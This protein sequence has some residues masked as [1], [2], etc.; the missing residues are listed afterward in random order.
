MV[1]YKLHLIRH[2]LTAGNTESRYI[3]GGTDESLC[4]QGI[5]SLNFLKTNYKYPDVQKIYTSPMKRAVET[6]EIIYPDRDYT[7]VD[8]LRECNFGE[9]ENQTFTQLSQNENFAKWISKGDEFAPK[10]GEKNADFAQR[11]ANGLNEVFMDMMKNNI[12]EAAC[13]CHGG[14]MAILLGMYAYPRKPFH[15]WTS[16]SGCGFTVIT[17]TQLWTRDN[18]VEAV[19]ILPIG[20]GEVLKQIHEN[21]EK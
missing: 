1:T 9:F 4:Q 20:W 17:D 10:G 6:C 8:N 5:D 18:A 16:D 21:K 14:V 11:C 3:G 15:E 19:E 2:G 13:V 12:T 7:A